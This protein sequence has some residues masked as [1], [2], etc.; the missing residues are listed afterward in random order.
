MKRTD[1]IFLTVV[2]TL[3][4]F[5]SGGIAC[6]YFTTGLNIVLVGIL[7][8]L[9]FVVSGYAACTIGGRKIERQKA[10]QKGVHS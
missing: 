9:I 1:K 8:V 2:G 4:F 3:M 10:S 5:V 7:G 6:T